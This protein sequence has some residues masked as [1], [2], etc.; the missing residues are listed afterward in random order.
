MYVPQGR[1]KGDSMSSKVTVEEMNQVLANDLQFMGDLG[2][3]FEHI[4]D[5]RVIARLPYSDKLL[6]PG[7]TLNGPAMMGMADAVLYAVVLSRIGMVKL[8]VTTSLTTNFLRRP[9][10]VDLIAEGKLIKCGR[11]LA[12]GEVSLFTDG[13]QAEPVCHVTGTYSIP[14]ESSR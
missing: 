3:I 10:P 12:Y 4:E 8:A 13:E 11:S 1:G 7:G 6:R 2:M 5:G 9:K 14:P